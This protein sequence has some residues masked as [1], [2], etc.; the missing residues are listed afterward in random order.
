MIRTE[1]EHF[2]QIKIHISEC[3]KSPLSPDAY[4]LLFVHLPH[5]CIL[6]IRAQIYKMCLGK[7]TI[8]VIIMIIVDNEK[9]KKNN[10][11]ESVAHRLASLAFGRFGVKNSQFYPFTEWNAKY[12]AEQLQI[13][14]LCTIVKSW[15]H[16][17]ISLLFWHRT[18][19]MS[20]SHTYTVIVF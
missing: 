20:Y 16:V 5:C 13:H 11:N 9:Q 8:I 17:S 1:S 2:I 12:I 15:L 14:F 19:T 18:T 4:S 6:T 7:I 3:V 10:N